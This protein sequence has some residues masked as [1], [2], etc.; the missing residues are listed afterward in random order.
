[1]RKDNSEKPQENDKQSG[2]PPALEWLTAAVGLILVAGT[3][4][5]LIYQTATEKHAPPDLSVETDSFIKTEKGYLVK[6]SVYNKGDENAADVVVEGKIAR[7]G[8]DLETSSV[9]IDYSPS[10]SK[11]EA[12]LFFTKNPKEFEL[13]IRPLGYK[14]P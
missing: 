14:K 4:G 5:F 13:N 8:E 2:K 11:R 7:G 6:F 9:T 12:G 10:H 3:I 1:M